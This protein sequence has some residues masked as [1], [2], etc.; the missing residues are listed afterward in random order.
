[1]SD[2]ILY[3]L[4]QR[5]F[6]D[7]AAAL[8]RLNEHLAIVDLP[9][10]LKAQLREL[11]F[12]AQPSL[13][14]GMPSFIYYF[15]PDSRRG[16]GQQIYTSPLHPSFLNSGDGI[17]LNLGCPVRL[18]KALDALTQLS[19]IDQ[20]APKNALKH[21]PG[22][23]SAVEELLWLTG[24]KRPTS[25]QRGGMLEGQN[26]DI[27]WRFQIDSNTIYLEAKFRRSDWV[28]LSDGGFPA[29][30]D[31]DYL[32]NSA[33]KFS[34]SSDGRVL[35]IVG[36]TTFDNLN[37]DILHRIGHEL[38]STPQI[39]AVVNRSLLGMTHIIS[40]SVEIR[41]RVLRLLEVPNITDFPGNHGVIYDRI[42]R[43]ARIAIQ[44]EKTGARISNVVCWPVVPF[45]VLPFPIPE[46]DLYRFAIPSRGS[47]GEPHFKIIPQF[48]LP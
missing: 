48:I 38:E 21:G 33:H 20:N 34:R 18:L 2:E 24:W 17:G 22:H 8:H 46:A 4:F 31:Q 16:T 6:D 27:D 23:L 1:M 26:G 45:G 41:D 35:H 12:P 7:P 9:F 30:L 29:E 42:Q 3:R 25:I 40:L 28:R 39:H 43:D 19:P 36:I 5:H 14:D 47:D 32:S 11:Q 37:E 44:P 10:D 15:V 13:P